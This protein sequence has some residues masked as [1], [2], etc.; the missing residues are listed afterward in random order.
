MVLGLAIGTVAMLG[1]LGFLAG[2]FVTRRLGARIGIG[3]VICLASPIGAAGMLIMALAPSAGPIPVLV[4]GQV[5]LGMGIALFNL[6]SL[7]LRQAITPAGLLGRVNAVVRLVG[8]GTI[9]AGA[10]LG[11]WLGG[12]IGLREVLV[13]CAIGSLLATA[14]PLFSAVRRVD[15][16][17]EP[18]PVW[19]VSSSSS[20]A[21]PA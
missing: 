8:W 16:T 1:N 13:V 3:P 19:A 2:T 18:E 6:Q 12:V 17:P 10:A 15:Q 9:P 4:A 5:I 7:S 11:G 14:L 21:R 20:A